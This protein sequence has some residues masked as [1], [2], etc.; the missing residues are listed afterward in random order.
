M[1]CASW[2]LR[3]AAPAS[4]SHDRDS[5]AE[6][7][8]SMSHAAAMSRASLLASWAMKVAF[9]DLSAAE[10]PSVGLAVTTSVSHA[11]P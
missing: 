5:G 1:R 11:G 2:S 10:T 3:S 6:L 9:E 4:D 7:V 8:T